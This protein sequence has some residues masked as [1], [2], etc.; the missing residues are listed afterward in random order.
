MRFLGS[1]V[2]NEHSRSMQDLEY[3]LNLLGMLL[4]FLFGTLSSNFLLALMEKNSG[5]I[6]SVG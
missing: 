3:I 4:Y 1:Q 2:S 5:H 6:F